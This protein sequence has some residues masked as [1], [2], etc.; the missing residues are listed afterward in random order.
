MV[1]VVVTVMVMVMVVVM[2]VA[3]VVVMLSFMLFIAI[4][5][6]EILRLQQQLKADTKAIQG[7]IPSLSPCCS[8]ETHRFNSVVELTYFQRQLCDKPKQMQSALEQ[9]SL[10]RTRAHWMHARSVG[11]MRMCTMQNMHAHCVHTPCVS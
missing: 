3:R 7:F 8:A 10:S 2:V 6:A 1:V 11:I 9:V 5:Q 4:I